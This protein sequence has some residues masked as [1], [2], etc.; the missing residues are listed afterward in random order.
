MTDTELIAGELIPYEPTAPPTLFGTSDPEVALARMAKVAAALVDVVRDRGLVVRISGREHL[1][2]E[3]WT[4]LGGML[5][6][7]PIVVWT[8]PL[9]D[10]AGWEARV[11]ARTLD[12]RVVGAAESMCTR[13]ERTWRDRDEYAL[14]SMAQTRAIGRAL[15]AP[16]GQVVRIAGYDPAGAEEIDADPE[17]PVAVSGGKSS[18]SINPDPEQWA[19]IRELLTELSEHDPGTDWP[20]TAR[21]LVGVPAEMMTRTLADGLIRQLERLVSVARATKAGAG[22]A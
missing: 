19:L 18:P 4:T 16:L 3:A 15:R 2:A 12:G 21:Q 22:Q 14:R 13:A 1:T 5:G 9:D 8:R 11:E 10:G 6:V 7:V 17:E 20:A